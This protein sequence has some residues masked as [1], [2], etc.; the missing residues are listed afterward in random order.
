MTERRDDSVLVKWSDNQIQGTTEP[1]LVKWS[2]RDPSWDQLRADKV[3]WQRARVGEFISGINF[4]F[5]AF[6]V[7][8]GRRR[9]FHITPN[10]EQ[11]VFVFEGEME[12]GVG[13]DPANL[14]WFRL[15]QYDTL[16]VPLG[17]GVDYRA[18]GQSDARFLTVYDRIGDW[19]RELIW[20]LPGED[21]PSVRRIGVAVG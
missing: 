18:V 6:H 9:P 19:S 8:F 1:V 17:Q 2:E 15:G 5:C 13:T 10:S 21:K 16:F 12:W 3:G 11:F 7:P 14:E 20:Q 4:R